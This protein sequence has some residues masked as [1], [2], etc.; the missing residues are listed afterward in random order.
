MNYI[1]EKYL[2]KLNEGLIKFD[3]YIISGKFKPEKNKGDFWLVHRKLGLVYLYYIEK[4]QNLKEVGGESSFYHLYSSG[5]PLINL[6]GKSSLNQ[7]EKGLKK[8]NKGN[9]RVEQ[10]TFTKGKSKLIFKGNTI[11]KSG[12]V[13]EFNLTKKQIIK[14]ISSWLI[15]FSKFS[16][17]VKRVK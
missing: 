13:L 5:E 7:I 16:G 15:P 4:P 17:I 8:K 3:G 9:V 1:I 10:P 6:L 2:Q 14:N 12:S 11:L